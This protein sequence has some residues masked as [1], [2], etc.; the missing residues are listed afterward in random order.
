MTS[1]GLGGI[2]RVGSV[3]DF[4]LVKFLRERLASLNV[5]TGRIRLNPRLKGVDRR[6]VK[7]HEKTFLARRRA[8]D[9]YTA[10]RRAALRVERGSMSMRQWRRY[11]SRLGALAR[12]HGGT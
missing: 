12:W 7:S 11:N 3:S 5:K 6:R 9:S 4:S 10:A 8:G 1:V 2:V